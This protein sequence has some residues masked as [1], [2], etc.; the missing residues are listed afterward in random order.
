ME[1]IISARPVSVFKFEAAPY[2]QQPPLIVVS[3]TLVDT[4]I[5]FRISIYIVYKNF[6]KRIIDVYLYLDLVAL[7]LGLSKSY[8]ISKQ[9]YNFKKERKKN[10]YVYQVE[11]NTFALC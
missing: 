5:I 1:A 10:K 3:Q 11:L 9:F 8:S 7:K 6:N 2:L 4:N